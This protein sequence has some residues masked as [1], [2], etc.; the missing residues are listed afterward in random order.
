MS[1]DNQSLDIEWYESQTAHRSDDPQLTVYTNLNGY[2]NAAADREWFADFDAMDI[3]FV[4]DEGLLVFR[5]GDDGRYSLSREADK[6]QGADVHVT[7]AIKH[8]WGDPGLKDTQKVPMRE[9]GGHIVADVSGLVFDD[10]A[11]D[12]VQEAVETA[13]ADPMEVADEVSEDTTPPADENE[14][15]AHPLFGDT[16]TSCP[17][18]EWAIAER[19]TSHDAVTVTASDLA[20]EVE[21][22]AP[23]AGRALNDL[24]ESKA[25][26]AIEREYH[27]DP[28]ETTQY[29]VTFRGERDD[30]ASESDDAA[31][32]VAAT[33]QAA[34][35]VES[36]QALADELD[37]SA[38]QARARA[39]DAGVYGDLQ[40]RVQRPGVER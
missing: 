7:S 31:D 39:R 24:G 37:V 30:D 6:G 12:R 35:D 25:P 34:D 2:I 21:T 20:E 28:A 19:L 29:H 9:A 11:D 33:L 22:S 16:Y 5:P 13:N 26:V 32:D 18:V 36:V 14:T 17:D 23:W 27:D 38:G 1:T 3:G 40:D 15:D 8:A 10:D 4:V